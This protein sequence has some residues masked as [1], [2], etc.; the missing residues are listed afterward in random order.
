MKKVIAIPVILFLLLFTACPKDN[1][2]TVQKIQEFLN[3]SAKG[4]EAVSVAAN[5]AVNIVI[6][7]M[8]ENSP[9][10][11]AILNIIG[12]VVKADTHGSAIVKSFVVSTDS[13]GNIVITSSLDGKT[14]SGLSSIT[15]IALTILKE[16]K[17]SLDDGLA[18][19][20]NPET[21]KKAQV[22]LD[23]I[24]IA[25]NTFQII[26]VSYGVQ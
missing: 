11:M 25:I 6:T 21:L 13:N 3:D 14:Y 22:Y 20:K 10:R 4:L 9:D 7:A 12:T 2:T 17:S 19:I 5:G 24:A 18:G 16:I 23:S 8:P 1:Q 26:L 15:P